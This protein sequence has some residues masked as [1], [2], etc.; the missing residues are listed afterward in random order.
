MKYKVFI[1]SAGIGSRL[2]PHTKLRNKALITL[3]D[4]PV[5]VRIIKKF[6]QDVEFV[7]ALGYR[8]TQIQQAV[9]ALCPNYKIEF[10]NI[11]KFEGEGASLGL[12]IAE[13]KQYLQTPFIFIPNDTIVDIDPDSLSPIRMGNWAG[14]YK[15]TLGDQVPTEQ[16]RTLDIYDGKVTQFNAKGLNSDNIYIGLAG[17]RDYN[18]F[19]K[20]FEMA[21]DIS[22]GEVVALDLLSNICAIEFKTWEDIGNLKSLQKATKKF[23]NY[24]YNILEKENE[25]IWFEKDQV[26]KFHVDSLFISDRV[27]R[28]DILPKGLF[29]KLTSFSDNTYS[30]DRVEGD[31]FS[32]IVS[33]HL[34]R[35]LLETMQKYLWKNT[36]PDSSDNKSITYEFYKAK[37]FSRVEYFFSRFERLDKPL[38][39]NDVKIPAARNL[40]KKVPW[41][42]IIKRAK[43]AEFHGDFHSENIIFRKDK[44]FCL[45]DWRQNFGANNYQ[46]GD[47][48]YDLSKFLHGLIVNHKEAECQNFIISKK[49]DNS[50]YIDIKMRYNNYKSI[51]ELKAWC[52]E[53]DYSFKN[54]ELLTGLIYLN[55]CGLH[56][57]PY[58]EFLFYLG[59]LMVFEN[60][61]E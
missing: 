8:G 40:L 51:K 54:V 4:L 25:A 20:F 21:T 26:T 12:T 18:A 9:E 28:L 30:Y 39:I 57:Y 22:A 58:A 23:R 34:V 56:E 17:I 55:I 7:I 45:L 31:I 15:K 61:D 59:M 35:K 44:T 48:Y 16:Y 33:P 36:C 32:S 5:I 19:W 24:A 37:S 1:P 47:V 38:Q 50:I 29:P 2:G 52:E 60:I 14:Y 46:Y 42:N 11:S 13:C 43:F 10:V 3:G 49:D 53:Y 6:P 27:K 41:N